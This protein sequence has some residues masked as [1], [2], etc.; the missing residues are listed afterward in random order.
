MQNPSES[1]S[2][3]VS[4]DVW[5]FLGQLKFMSCRSFSSFRSWTLGDWM[6]AQFGAVGAVW[7]LESFPF[8]PRD[9]QVARLM[10]SPASWPAVFLADFCRFSCV[11]RGKIVATS[12]GLPD[13]PGRTWTG[14]I[15]WNWMPRKLCLEGLDEVAKDLQVRIQ[16]EAN[17]PSN[18]LA[19]C[20]FGVRRSL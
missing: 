9:D 19:W 2:G 7:W 5:W 3:I 17:G 1:S 18:Q 12:W 14:V 20:I 10:R 8:A 15:Q 4:V 13:G 16:V 11:W 6:E